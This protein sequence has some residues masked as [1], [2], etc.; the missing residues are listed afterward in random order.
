MDE[1]RVV[2]PRLLLSVGILV[3]FLFSAIA[4]YFAVIYTPD[5]G[6]E[7]GSRPAAPVTETST[8]QLQPPPP[9]V[10][11]PGMPGVPC[12]GWSGGSS[13]GTECTPTSVPGPAR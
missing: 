8:P 11:L 3:G 12:M 7:S 10:F 1:R 13:T 6:R 4:I 9:P 2:N 5:S